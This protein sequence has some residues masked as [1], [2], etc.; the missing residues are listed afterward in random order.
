VTPSLSRKRAPA[1][2]SPGVFLARKQSSPPPP[3]PP[4][5]NKARN[6]ASSHF[7]PFSVP[8]ATAELRALPLFSEEGRENRAL[9]PFGDACVRRQAGNAPS[10]EKIEGSD[11]SPFPSFFF[12]LSS[13]CVEKLEKWMPLPF[14]CIKGRQ[15]LDSS[16]TIYKKEKGTS[17]P[18][19]LKKGRNAL[20]KSLSEELLEVL[21]RWMI[22]RQSVFHEARENIDSNALLLPR[23]DKADKSTSIRSPPRKTNLCPA[24]LFSERSA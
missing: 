3:P 14:L 6:S 22:A 11:L 19:S 18:S 23:F 15:G 12:F 16:P 13:L 21:C 9:F 24:P 20:C 8:P 17:L 2:S 1:F 7:S 5:R 10:L 4:L